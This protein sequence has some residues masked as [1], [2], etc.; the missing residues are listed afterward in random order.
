[1]KVKSIVERHLFMN[2]TGFIVNSKVYRHQ[3]KNHSKRWNTFTAIKTKESNT[4]KNVT[5]VIYCDSES[6]EWRGDDKKK[7]TITIEIENTKI[8]VEEFR[9]YFVWFVG[10]TRAHAH[11][12]RARIENDSKYL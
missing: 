5:N 2:K 7:K 4:Q 9:E 8:I 1:M 12:R 6:N 3:T 11:P 10:Y